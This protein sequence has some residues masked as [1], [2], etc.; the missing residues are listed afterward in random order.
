MTILSE[1]EAIPPRGP[2]RPAKYPWADWFK[3][4]QTVRV[5][6]GTHYDISTENFRIQI[7]KAAKRYGGRV[8]T[9][10]VGHGEGLTFTFYIENEGYDNDFDLGERT[11]A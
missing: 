3:H 8:S 2:G 11:S 6:K 1:E 9:R 10:D 5:T 7:N 4:G